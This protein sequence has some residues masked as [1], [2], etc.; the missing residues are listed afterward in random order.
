MWHSDVVGLVATTVAHE[1]G[2]NFGMEHDTEGCECPDDKCIMAPASSTMKPSFWSS[3]SLE[4][5]SDCIV[6]TIN[7]RYFVGEKKS[8]IYRCNCLFHRTNP[9]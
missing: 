8:Q 7:R 5:Y 3:C 1:M 4:M 9:F 6:I 2:H